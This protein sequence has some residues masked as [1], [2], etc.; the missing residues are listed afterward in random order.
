MQSQGYVRSSRRRTGAL[1]G[2]GLFFAGQLS[3]ANAVD[4]LLPGHWLEVPGSTLEAHDPAD[5][6][7]LNPNWPGLAPWHGVSGLPAIMSAWSSAAFDTMRGR[8]AIWGGGHSDY[9]GNEVYVFDVET[10]AWERLTAPSIDVSVT[11]STLYPDGQPRARE[12]YNYLEFLPTVDRMVS[13]GG[14]NLFP[15]AIVTSELAAFDFV[16]DTWDATSLTPHPGSQFFMYGAAVSVDQLTGHA[17]LAQTGYSPVHEYDPVND[18]WTSHSRSDLLQYRNMAIDQR[19]RYLVWTGGHGNTVG[20]DLDNPSALAFAR[21]TTGDTEIEFLQF[22]G[23]AWDPVSEQI[24]AWSGGDAVYSLNTDSSTW[25]WT[26]IDPDPANTVVPTSPL[27]NGTHGRFRYVPQKNAFILVNRVSDNV[28]FYKLPGPALDSDG[29]GAPDASDNCILEA[30]GPDVPDAGGNV[31]LDSDGDGI[32]NACDGDIA[33]VNDCVVNFPDLNV[34]KDAFFST[35][36]MPDWNPD[37]DGNGDGS[38]NFVDLNLL[39]NNFF[40]DYAVDNP[41]GVANDC[42]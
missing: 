30:N 3:W 25:V 22:P 12:T 9:A 33:V 34:M 21:P 13:F 29:D 23:M 41:S 39:K 27:V 16:T 36:G 15:G 28:F 1:V 14:G 32:G 26:R 35:T 4:D 2:I 40:R 38:V 20:F 31:Q 24:I 19:N 17:W 18:S 37:A 7:V 8:L 6:P 10:L 11:G 5:D 42:M